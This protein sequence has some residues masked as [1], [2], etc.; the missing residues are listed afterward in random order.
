MKFF[1]RNSAKNVPNSIIILVGMSSEFKVFFVFNFLLNELAFYVP[2]FWK[3]KVL[4]DS[5]LFVL[6]ATMLG[7]HSNFVIA[8][9][10]SLFR[11][12]LLLR[13]K[14]ILRLGTMFKPWHCLK[15]IIPT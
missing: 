2:T 9:S 12:S 1:D 7:C 11:S 13:K 5:F 6:L 3:V 8:L 10:I 14:V 4:L 15:R